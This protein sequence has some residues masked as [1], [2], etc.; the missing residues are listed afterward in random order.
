M[1]WK[2]SIWCFGC[3]WS[4]PGMGVNHGIGDSDSNDQSVSLTSASS[5]DSVKLF[6]KDV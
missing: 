6:A 4:E 2:P 5:S 3:K 1:A